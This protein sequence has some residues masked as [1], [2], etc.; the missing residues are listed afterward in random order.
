M[1]LS[2]SGLLGGNGGRG[3]VVSGVG[4]R[5]NS[6]QLSLELEHRLCDI[7]TINHY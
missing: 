4:I 5:P 6:E 1:K 7:A 3:V 2:G